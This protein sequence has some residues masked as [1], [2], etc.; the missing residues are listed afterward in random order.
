MV[1]TNTS[2][3]SIM[4][5]FGGDERH[6]DSAQ[7]ATSFQ[8]R[9]YDGELK[10]H[11]KN[12]LLTNLYGEWFHLNVTHDVS[13]HEIQVFTNGILAMTFKDNGGKEWHMKCGVYAQKKRRAKWRSFIGT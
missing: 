7:H 1:V 9:V 11:D 12:V 4:Q 3:V 13:T 8:L 2:K 10:W 5:V 6:E